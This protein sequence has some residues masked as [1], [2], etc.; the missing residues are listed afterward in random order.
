M[1]T[2]YA[3]RK[4]DNARVGEGG[5]V[6]SSWLNSWLLNYSPWPKL[7]EWDRQPQS[8]KEEFMFFVRGKLSQARVEKDQRCLWVL[9]QMQNIRF[10]IERGDL[11]VAY[12]EDD[13]NVLVGFAAFNRYPVSPGDRPCYVYV[14]NALRHKG[15]G[16]LLAGTNLKD[17][18]QAALKDSN[19]RSKS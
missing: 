3:V 12:P 10:A 6:F 11:L 8:F 16:S 2:G 4:F 7:S 15:L 9:T 14:S 1:T 18:A 19:A 13:P 5:F 17:A